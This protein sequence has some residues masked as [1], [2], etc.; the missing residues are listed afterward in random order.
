MELDNDL[1]PLS[2]LMLEDNLLDVELARSKLDQ[3][4]REYQLW[5][6]ETRAEFEALLAARAYD[7]VLADY[8]LPDFDGLAALEMVRER[9]RHVPFIFVSGTLGEEVAVET[10]HRGATDYVLKQKLDRMLPAI[11]RAMKEYSAHRSRLEVES[12]LAE[13]ELRFQQMTNVL[14]ALLWTANH[15][16]ILTYRNDAWNA[17]V[18]APIAS[19]WCD[20]SVLHVDDVSHVSRQWRDSL[21]NGS[22]LECECRFRR[23]DGVYLWHLVRV[24]PLYKGEAGSSWIGTCTEIEA[25]KNRE[26][27][28][29]IS[30]KLV[31]IG[32]MAGA[33]A[34]EIN[35]PLESL[36]NLLYLLRDCDVREEPGRTYLDEADEQLHRI[37]SITKQ[38]LSFYRDKVSLGDIDC[39]ALI[40]E[41]MAL[42]RA[43]LRQK[44]IQLILAIEG[45]VHCQAR[46]GEIRQVLINLVSNA[47]DAM[48]SGGTLRLG[49]S[50]IGTGPDSR[51]CLQVEDSGHGIPDEVR[52]RL[53]EPFYSTKGTLGTGLGLWVTKNIVERH[54]GSVEI[55]SRPGRTQFSVMLP[56][57]YCG[58]A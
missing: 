18:G 39:K 12:R 46:T 20:V 44:Q 45:R 16:G 36:T 31:V 30:E 11:D 33:I 37:A 51:V 7:V 14:P 17:Y 2:I 57:E 32:R 29:R 13:S 27:L 47:I 49:A 42:F 21:K 1:R 52:A 56:C 28:L 58:E 5:S 26:E 54:H 41:T 53:F 48:E 10:L 8:S 4:G 19:T 25:Q 38:T 22:P 6:A 50:Q 9:D 15:D 43:K 24:V 3:I 55:E 23:V 40:E 34:H 35:N